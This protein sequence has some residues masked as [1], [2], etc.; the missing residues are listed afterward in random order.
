MDQ[1]SKLIQEM[2]YEMKDHRNDGWTKEAYKER[3]KKI[4][5]DIEKALKDED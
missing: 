2:I 5:Q 3:L 1:F 4:K